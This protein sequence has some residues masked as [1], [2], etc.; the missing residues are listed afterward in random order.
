MFKQ[1]FRRTLQAAASGSL[2][3]LVM[4]AVPAQA[5]EPTLSILEPK[6]GQT[7]TSPFRVRLAAHSMTTRPAGKLVEGTGHHHVL[8][9]HGAVGKGD[10]IP[11][12]DTHIHLDNGQ[13][14]T[15]LSLPPGKY[16]LTA[17]FADGE[18]RSYGHMMAHGINITVK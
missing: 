18:H 13:T 11:H 7:V 4:H 5:D 12:D 16:K 8:I 9:N 3:M 2:L 14:E 1:I 15:M 10:V 17:Q 6:S